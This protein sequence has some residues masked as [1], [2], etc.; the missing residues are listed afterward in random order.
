MGGR[1]AIWQIDL[2]VCTT[3]AFWELFGG[4]RWGGI[5]KCVPLQCVLG[6][7]GLTT[8]FGAGSQLVRTWIRGEEEELL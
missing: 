5:L 2:I 8:R 6:G 3:T 4:R 1:I 7:T